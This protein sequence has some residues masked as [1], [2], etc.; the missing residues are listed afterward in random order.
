MK[1][2]HLH[3]TRKGEGG[4][5]GV[6]R[7]PPRAKK[8]TRN[9][10][11]HGRLKNRADVREPFYYARCGG[12]ICGYTNVRVCG[13]KYV[14]LCVHSCA[15]NIATARRTSVRKIYGSA[16][17]LECQEHAVPS[18][19]REI[20][21]FRNIGRRKFRLLSSA[22]LG[23]RDRGTRREK[24]PAKKVKVCTRLIRER[25]ARAREHSRKLISLFGKQL[26][27]SP[28][29]PHT[30]THTSSSYGLPRAYLLLRASSRD[31][32][33]H[34][35]CVRMRTRDSKKGGRAIRWQLFHI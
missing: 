23:Q 3:R 22:I 24:E 21:S 11:I 6:P 33:T 27:S 4:S 26:P 15:R 29:F 35:R 1:R 17:C 32:R 28:H 9:L 31:T 19:R 13:D 5:W 14:Y 10:L 7:R 12:R 2:L 30:H 8:N 18:A 34:P 25:R 20:A 16:D